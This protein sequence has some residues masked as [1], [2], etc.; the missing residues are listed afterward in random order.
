[1]TKRNIFVIMTTMSEIIPKNT[2]YNE[3][4]PVDLYEDIYDLVTVGEGKMTTHHRPDGKFLS[5]YE[6][7]MIRENQDLIRGA[8]NLTEQDQPLSPNFEDNPG[9]GAEMELIDAQSEKSAKNLVVDPSDENHEFSLSPEAKEDSEYLPRL[10]SVSR[11]A[12]KAAG[13]PYRRPSERRQRQQEQTQ[14]TAS[15]VQNHER[16]ARAEGRESQK[17]RLG[18]EINETLR[19][20]QEM[21]YSG[22]KPIELLRPATRREKRAEAEHPTALARRHTNG[23]FVWYDELQTDPR[24]RFLLHNYRHPQSTFGHV[25]IGDTLGLAVPRR[26]PRPSEGGPRWGSFDE[27]RTGRPAPEIP[28]FAKKIEPRKPLAYKHAPDPEATTHNSRILTLDGMVYERFG[29]FDSEGIKNAG[30]AVVAE[31]AR[32]FSHLSLEDQ[33]II[34]AQLQNMHREELMN[35]QAHEHDLERRRRSEEA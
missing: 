28:W 9:S 16:T 25:A 15:R 24:V 19:K 33:E 10:F 23:E 17:E 26:H 14:R 12:T 18:R 1:M 21:E 31:E 29:I 35:R 27:T 11:V 22:I 3:Q 8:G 5:K 20:L 2:N 4:N 34:L 6:M 7:D 30:H 13:Q 32:H